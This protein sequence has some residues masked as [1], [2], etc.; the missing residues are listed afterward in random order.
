MPRG[1]N[2]RLSNIEVKTMNT[3]NSTIK[4]FDKANWAIDEVNGGYYA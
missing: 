3:L 4:G 2:S 1:V